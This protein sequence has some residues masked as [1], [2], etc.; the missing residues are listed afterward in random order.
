MATMHRLSINPLPWILGD[1]GYNLSFEVVETALMDLK[2]AGY[3]AMTVEWTADMDVPTYGALFARHGMFPAPGYFSGAFHDASEHAALV[4]GIKRHAEAHASFGLDQAFIA[5]DLTPERIAAPA[6]G[7][8]ESTQA[9]AVIAEGMALAAEAAAAVGVRYGLHP[10]VGSLVEVESEVREVLDRSAGSALGFGPDTGHL[11]WAGVDPVSVIGDYAD[12]VVA[13]HIKDVDLQARSAAIKAGDDYLAAT[14]RRHVWIEPGRGQTDF[15]GVLAALPQEWDGWTV[16]EVDVP[17][18]PDR[19]ASS[20]F[21][22]EYL[23]EQ[24]FYSRADDLGEGVK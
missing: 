5:A 1:L 14:L 17:N 9:S 18:L 8:G 3:T 16:V 6:V 22:L 13:L 20:R 15:A 24:P 19:M 23:T 7:A 21:A 12:R 10:H 11:V 2:A 4:E